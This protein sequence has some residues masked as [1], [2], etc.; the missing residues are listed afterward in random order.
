VTIAEIKERIRAIEGEA[1][2]PGDPEVAHGLE[3][4]LW[5]DVLRY[6]AQ[7]APAELGEIA[8]LA[9][10]TRDIDFPRWTA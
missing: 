6:L 4:G 10:S 2:A 7:V 5:E 3:D 1:E 9:V 8:R